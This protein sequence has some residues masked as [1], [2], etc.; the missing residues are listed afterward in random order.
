MDKDRLVEY[1]RKMS[2]TAVDLCSLV[3]LLLGMDEG[4]LVE[5]LVTADGLSVLPTGMTLVRTLSVVYER[6]LPALLSC[7]ASSDGLEKLQGTELRIQIDYAGAKCLE[8]LGAVLTLCIARSRM[9]HGDI[10]EQT[11]GVLWI[12]IL[13][14]QCDVSTAALSGVHSGRLLR[15]LS[16]AFETEYRVLLVQSAAQSLGVPAADDAAVDQAGYLTNVL[17][18]AFKSHA[19]AAADVDGTDDGADG[20][21]AVVC[22]LL[23]GAA[24][25]GR[26]VDLKQASLPQIMVPKQPTASRAVYTVESATTA[27]KAIFPDYGDAFISACLQVSIYTLYLGSIVL[28]YARIVSTHRNTTTILIHAW[29]HCYQRPSRRRSVDWTEGPRQSG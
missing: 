25:I 8:T 15:D 3:Q 23:Y 18:E 16:A 14:D 20:Q 27:I 21:S 28:N 4:H 24:T 9:Q 7:I 1:I 22:D 19:N 11:T 26:F 17:R 6:A 29:T 10:K 5:R 12:E 13:R 2:I